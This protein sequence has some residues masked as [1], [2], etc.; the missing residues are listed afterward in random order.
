MLREP[1]ASPVTPRKNRASPESDELNISRTRSGKVRVVVSKAPDS[2][3]DDIPTPPPSPT[4][5]RSR[6][7]RSSPIKPPPEVLLPPAKRRKIRPP[8][9]AP[10]SDSEPDSGLSSLPA[11]SPQPHEEVSPPTSVESLIPNVADLSSCLNAQ[12]RHI[13]RT[14]L[15]PPDLPDEDADSANP[16]ALKQ[17]RD[18]L[19]GTVERGEGNSCLVIGPRGSGKTRIVDQCLSELQQNPIILRLCGWS[20][21]TDR[22]AMREIAYQLNQQTGRSFLAAGEEEEA[23]AA[24]EAD[25]FLEAPNVTTSLPPSTH[26]PALI[27]LIPTL[28]RPTVIILDGFDLFALHPRQSL[29]YCLL[30]TAQSCR[31]GS[32]DKGI[33]VIGVTTRIDSLTLLEKRV[34]SRFSGRMFSTA[35]PPQ[36]QDWVELARGILSSRIGDDS[37]QQQWEKA[38]HSFLEDKTTK[39]VLNETFSVTR[40]VRVL[41]RLL[42]S[43]TLQLSPTYPFPTSKQLLAA[44]KEQ[45]A[46]PRFPILHTLP[47]PSA[48]LLIA[49]IHS[50]TAGHPIFTFEMLFERVRDQIRVS[51]SAPVEFNGRSIGMPQCSR[52]VLM[53]AFQ[54]LVSARIFTAVA[55]PS[56]TVAREF[57][58]YRAVVSRE[59]VKKAIK[60]RSDINLE[61]WLRKAQ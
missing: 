57:A 47:Y 15:H 27:S 7:T 56:A 33:A 36:T 13:L 20:Q 29:L 5:G 54:N 52:L 2:D 50:E 8:S 58:K 34:K 55:A 48:C 12:K 43:V 19:K 44:A 6:I 21:Q 10:D 11:S 18:L 37:W 46:R 22:L 42:T 61:Q 14:I 17:L 1:D 40:D 31:A 49:C 39:S 59:D 51:S 35:P 4:K 25:P 26:L 3:S 16:I 32:G 53:S 38:V 60:E 28:S 41:A 45:R 30:D 23:E 24:E 9:P